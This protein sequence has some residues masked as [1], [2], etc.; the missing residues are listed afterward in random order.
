MPD[1]I[2]LTHC[3]EYDASALPELLNNMM[4]DA[5]FIPTRG[6]R[7]LVKP[8]MVGARNAGLSNTHPQF[9]RAAC[10]MLLE[11]GVTVT[12][13]DSPSFGSAR[14]VARRSGLHLA[15]S[16]LPVS[17]VTLCRPE[18]TRLSCGQ[19]IG[20]SRDA[21]ETDAIVNL[22]KLKVHNQMC[23]T[24]STKNLFGCVCGARKA[25]TH[26]HHGDRD[27]IFPRIIL[28]IAE[29][30]PARVHLL[31][32]VTTMHVKGPIWGK[33]F[34]LGLVGCS[35]NMH[36]LDAAVYNILGLTP[37]EVPL[38]E[39]ARKLG[40]PGSDLAGAYFPLRTPQDFDATGFVLPEKLDPETFD[41]MRLAKGRI[42][43]VLQRFF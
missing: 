19:S 18:R 14:S 29:T 9:I 16:D 21:L 26:Y 10:R 1:S 2:L 41:P 31:D 23:V 43:S 34:H 27:G 20:I 32:A 12:V 28:D 8:N 30:V 7:V 22:P 3:P 24:A 4:L 35:T 13:G 39:T 17:L 6:T 15:L 33:P 5:G 37:D 42:K 11:H 38:W 25:L 40:R 36:A